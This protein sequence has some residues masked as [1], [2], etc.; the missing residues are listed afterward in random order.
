MAVEGDITIS[1]AIDY[2]FLSFRSSKMS[3]VG[4]KRH[5]LGRF[6]KFLEAKIDVLTRCVVIMTCLTSSGRYW[7]ACA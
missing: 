2:R 6:H 5:L 1:N 7:L 3:E 4:L